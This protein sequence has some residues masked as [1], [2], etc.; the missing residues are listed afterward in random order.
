MPCG[1]ERIAVHATRSIRIACSI[2]LV[3]NKSSPQEETNVS[4][5]P[6]NDTGN[7]VDNRSCNGDANCKGEE[8]NMGNPGDEDHA[9]ALWVKVHFFF[10]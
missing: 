9:V 5:S 4:V 3:R 1:A 10:I 7:N 8:L 2:G 6:L